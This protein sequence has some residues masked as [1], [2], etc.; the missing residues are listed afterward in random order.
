[1]LGRLPKPSPLSPIE[2]KEEMRRGAVVV[3]ARTSPAFGGAHIKGSY[4]IWLEGLPAY[5]G[6][7][8]TYG[9]PILLVLEC[10]DHLDKAVRY[11]LRLGYDNIAGYLRGGIEAWYNSGFKIEYMGLSS[12]HELKQRLDSG[13]DV[14]V[15]D[16]RDENEWKEGH[17]KG[18][19][20]VYVGQLESR[21]SEIPRDRSI[22][23]SAM[24]VIVRVWQQAYFIVR[25]I[26][27]YVVTFLGVRK[28]G[29]P[30][31]SQ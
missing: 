10:S 15:L 4:S 12:V 8:L 17:I 23:T 6:W 20:R 30:A 11:L 13:K 22:T 25:A 16:V 26:Q 3:D 1:M 14:L 2:F 31:S 18:A 5:A 27:M 29:V 7:V 21:L 19:L 9:K 24:W 28:L